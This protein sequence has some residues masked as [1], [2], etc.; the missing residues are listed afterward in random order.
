MPEQKYSQEDVKLPESDQSTR[1]KGSEVPREA[2]KARYSVGT[3]TVA[4]KESPWQGELLV[5]NRL[6]RENSWSAY[7]VGLGRA[8]LG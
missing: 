7:G 2:G 3:V 6:G 1:V 4:G 8:T 5:K